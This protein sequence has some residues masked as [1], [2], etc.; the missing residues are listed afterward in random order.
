AVTSCARRGDGRGV[1]EV[2]LVFHGLGPA[3]DERLDPAGRVD[4]DDDE[5]AGVGDDADV[6]VGPVVLGQPLEDAVGDTPVGDGVVGDARV[7][8]PSVLSV[9][10]DEVCSVS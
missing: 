7:R 6:D 2:A 5:A 4:G 9:T 3:S 1:G 10:A 8:W